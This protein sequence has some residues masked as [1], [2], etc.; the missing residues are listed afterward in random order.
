MM[1]GNYYCYDNPAAL[2]TQLEQWVGKPSNYGITKNLL[3]QIIMII[4]YIIIII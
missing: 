1:V 2:H 4:I 3:L